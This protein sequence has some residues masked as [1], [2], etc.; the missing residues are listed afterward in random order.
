VTASPSDLHDAARAL[1]HDTSRGSIPQREEAVKKYKAMVLYRDNEVLMAAEN[2]ETLDPA[3]LLT[4]RT[5]LRD[6][7]NK[8]GAWKAGL[9]E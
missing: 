2:P 3:F 6:L 1:F 4:D 8:M 5:V 9:E 7:S